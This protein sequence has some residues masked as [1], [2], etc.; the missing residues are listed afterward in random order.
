M[1]DTLITRKHEILK[2]ITAKFQENNWND[3]TLTMK[4][5]NSKIRINAYISGE[6]NPWTGLYSGTKKP[7]SL[8]DANIKIYMAGWPDNTPR[9]VDVETLLNTLTY[10]ERLKKYNVAQHHI[11]YKNTHSDGYANLANDPSYIWCDE[12][13]EYIQTS[14]DS[15]LHQHKYDKGMQPGTLA[16][17]KINVLQDCNFAGY[18]SVETETTGICALLEVEHI[19]NPI[20]GYV[21]KHIMTYIDV[22]T[23]EIKS[24]DLVKPHTDYG[25]KIER[26]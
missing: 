10:Y 3:I 24:V 5:D 9:L 6:K 11:T 23:L 16:S 20:D 2:A 19:E 26:L 18:D 12:I 17:Y 8:Y 1:K 21:S 7:T 13:G 25:F 4:C 15:D 22:N 14:N